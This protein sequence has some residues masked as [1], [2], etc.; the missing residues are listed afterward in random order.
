MKL[1]LWQTKNRGNLNPEAIVRLLLPSLASSLAAIELDE[2]HN[3][4]Y[5][6]AHAMI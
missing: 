6:A 5:N 1:T 4:R 2:M 3:P